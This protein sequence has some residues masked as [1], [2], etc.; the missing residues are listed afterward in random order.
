MNNNILENLILMIISS[1][2]NNTKITTT[3][4]RI[5]TLLNEPI[6]TLIYLDINNNLILPNDDDL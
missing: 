5:W 6:E 4:I 2:D 1:M 3:D